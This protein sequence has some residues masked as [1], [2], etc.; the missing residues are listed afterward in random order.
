[1]ELGD[2]LSKSFDRL[3]DTQKQILGRIIDS[4]NAGVKVT[5]NPESDLCKNKEFSGY[6]ANLFSV[7]HS[8]TE[9]KFEKKSFEF[10][11]KYASMASGFESKINKNNSHQGEDVTRGE[12][13]I[14]LKTE[15]E[16]SDNSFK[17]SKFSEA[18]FIANYKTEIEEN[19]IKSLPESNPEKKSKQRKLLHRRQEKL[20]PKLVSDFKSTVRHHLESYDRI[21]GLKTRAIEKEDEIQCY[22]YR[23]IEIPKSLLEKSLDL[24][25]ADFKPL[26]GNGGTS[27]VINVEGSRAFGVTLDGSVEKIS[28]TGIKISHCITHAEFIVP[29]SI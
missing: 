12:E 4:F 2:E 25:A 22:R 7:Y 5:V 9:H 17:I 23:L 11:F 6:F 16:R 1:M 26:R 21:I 27:A 29:V 10:A 24:E 8:I 3:S 18:R 15:G 14:S 19:Q 20:L 13:K 28:I